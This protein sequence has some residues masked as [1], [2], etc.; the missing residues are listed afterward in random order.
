V[1]SDVEKAKLL[2][3]KI[4]MGIGTK[5]AGNPESDALI[6][7]YFTN[8]EQILKD[9]GLGNSRLKV[10]V[11]GG[12]QHNEEAWARRLPDALLFLYGR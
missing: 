3:Q 9:R 5:E 6:L 10:I 7:K 4:Y 1:L 11:E 12:G 2:P 8:M